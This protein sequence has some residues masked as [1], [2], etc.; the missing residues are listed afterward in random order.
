MNLDRIFL[1]DPETLRGKLLLLVLDKLV[2]GAVL[3]FAFFGYD[4]WKTREVR[5]YNEVRQRTEL[6]FKRAEYVKELVP[7]A[8]DPTGDV[9]V[10]AQALTALVDT[11]A[12]S[13]MSAV[14]FAGRLLLSDV[15]A[16]RRYTLTYENPVNGEIHR[17]TL[18]AEGEEEVL[19]NTLLKVMPSGLPAVLS[20]FAHARTQHRI[21]T[22][23]STGE[24]TDIEESRILNDAVGFW[25]RLFRETTARFDDEELEFLAAEPFLSN[26]LALLDAIV[27]SLD[28][29][30]A[31]RWLRRQNEALK[32]LGALRLMQEREPTDAAVEFLRESVNPSSGTPSVAFATQVIER[33]HSHAVVSSDLSAETL[34]VVLAGRGL[35]LG[36]IEE[37]RDSDDH[38]FAASEYLVWS[39]RFPQIAEPLE[40]EVRSELTQFLSMIQSTPVEDLDYE[41]HPV[42][43][44][45]V[46][47]LMDSN[48]ASNLEPSPDAKRLLRGLFSLEQDKLVRTGLDH[49]AREWRAHTTGRR[50]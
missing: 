2:I 35:S 39:G 10:R 34:L 29:Q 4:L 1:T 28:R 42:E 36:V 30:D 45:L 12:I 43:W 6:G 37:R 21:A 22:S 16:A 47:F 50:N 11:E 26:N 38:F 46:R 15:L 3:A 40:E 8:L 48:S 31:Q 5:S 27:P 41:N 7:V 20:E 19:L 24:R 13:P 25:I 9:L 14:T 17:R 23:R 32:T 49:Y 18:S 33:L 44:T